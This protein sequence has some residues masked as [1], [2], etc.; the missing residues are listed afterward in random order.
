MGPPGAP[1]KPSLETVS[2]V[3][4]HQAVRDAWLHESTALTCNNPPWGIITIHHSFEFLQRQD[5]EILSH[6]GSNRSPLVGYRIKMTCWPS[7]GTILGLSNRQLR[8]T[9]GV[10][11]FFGCSG[12]R[13]SPGR[14]RDAFLKA[15]QMGSHPPPPLTEWLRPSA[16]GVAKGDSPR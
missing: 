10:S 14:H 13:L 15:G 8:R 11:H 3:M 7:R 4:G 12:A 5:R 1:E 16:R 6:N 2:E 9:L